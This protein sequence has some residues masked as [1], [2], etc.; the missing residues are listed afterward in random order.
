MTSR[1]SSFDPTQI[2]TKE[3]WDE[4]GARSL[5]MLLASSRRIEFPVEQSPR[6]SIILVLHNKAHL[7]LLCLDALTFAV[8]VPFEPIIVDNASTDSTSALL[9]RCVNVTVIRNSTNIGFGEACMQGV[10]RARG[11]FLLFL[12]ND[13]FLR[14]GSV[15]AA[16]RNFRQG[17][18]GAV[19]GKILL[20][21]G[22]LQEAGSIVWADGSA[23]GYGRG[24][25][26]S[27]AQYCFRRP[28]D[29]CS[30]AFLFTP[31]AL[32]LELGGFDA[33]YAPA[34]YEDTDY[35]MKLWQAGYRVVYEPEAVIHHYESASS[36]GNDQAQ[37]R[38]AEKQR[39]FVARWHGVL[40]KNHYTRSEKAILRA[41]TAAK[42]SGP[43]M[44]YIDDCIPHRSQGSGYPRSNDILRALAKQGHFVTVVPFFSR[45]WSADA[46]YRDINRNVELFDY[47][48][49]EG[50]DDNSVLFFDH[51]RD[52]R[53]RFQQYV[54]AADIV[55]ISRP[56][57]LTRFL[58]HLVERG[59]MAAKLVFDAEAVFTDREKLSITIGRRTV[60][61]RIL[62]ARRR[63]E[64]VL[65][66]AADVVTVVS[67]RDCEIFAA[68]GVRNLHVL[69]HCL[70]AKPTMKPFDERNTFL[71]VGAVHGPE[72][73]NGDSMRYF[74]RE[75]WP[76]VRRSTN[77]R[78]VIAGAGTD[79][80]LNDLACDNIQVLG[81]VVDLTPLYNSARVVVVPTRYAAGIPYKAHEAASF[82]VPL[83]VSELIRS[84]LEWED[85]VDLLSASNAA[86]FSEKCIRLYNDQELWRELRT[87][88]LT[89]ILCEFSRESFDNKVVEI[90]RRA[91]LADGSSSE[92]K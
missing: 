89:R 6:I 61:P 19:G 13:A 88:S 92:F 79:Y 35:C 21:D 65:A 90:I 86:C 22:R 32:F 12:N 48:V 27:A 70:E 8:G 44:L 69:G 40:E 33:I 60:A 91:T 46:E 71:F 4:H 76:D 54:E 45:F 62:D 85:G 26:P 66:D 59:Q 81:S 34:Y 18:V 64:F 63:G 58:D 16:L 43:R 37:P 53:D 80:Y 28:V 47:R 83:V 5:A 3:G 56:H 1:L 77:A 11:E 78:M 14:Q 67:H 82:G 39:T 55:W 31:K 30:G 75:I 9:D 68:A 51:R 72:T 74:C 87:N 50:D 2:I 17:D 52:I 42:P 24:D 36:G 57:N 84:Q 25:D 38:M 23:L 15:E 7:S 49:R 20:A 10:E 41:R 73:P 29:Y